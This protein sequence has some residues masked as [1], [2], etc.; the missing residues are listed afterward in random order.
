MKNIIQNLM[1]A[2]IL[3]GITMAGYAQKPQ[4]SDFDHPVQLPSLAKYKDGFVK[5]YTEFW[6]KNE[7]FESTINPEIDN[8]GNNPPQEQTTAIRRAINMQE[9]IDN[10]ARAV[11]HL[12]EE[13]AQLILRIQGD[14]RNA[15]QSVEDGSV[16]LGKSQGNEAETLYMQGIHDEFDKAFSEGGTPFDK[17]IVEEIKFIKNNRESFDRLKEAITKAIGAISPEKSLEDARE[18]INI[19]Q[20][21]TTALEF[22]KNELSILSRAFKT[23]F[24]RRESIIIEG[25]PDLTKPLYDGLESMRMLADSLETISGQ[26][27]QEPE[28]QKT[29][30]EI[31]KMFFGDAR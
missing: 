17:D 16:T 19:I 1:L 12:I 22:R 3:N 8:L 25:L 5:S 9:Q 28:A 14:L 18:F 23:A 15:G 6:K 4:A 26:K 30:P 21:H 11:D 10:H 24:N 7:V 20:K 31:H 2:L 29:D 13:N 27:N